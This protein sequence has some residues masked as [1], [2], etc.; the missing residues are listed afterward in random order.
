[1]TSTPDLSD[2]PP[3]TREEARVFVRDHIRSQLP[4]LL[5]TWKAMATPIDFD[6]LIARGV[7]RK[8]TGSWYVL[9]NPDGLSA[10]AGHRIKQIMQV[11][12]KG[13]TVTKVKFH[14]Y[15][16]FLAT[17]RKTVDLERLE[18]EVAGIERASHP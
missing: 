11:T 18:R 9:L 10:P 4:R 14:D 17:L 15:T 6:D 5:A 8:T 13:Q 2:Y 3:S 1:M 7:L 16:K 12:R